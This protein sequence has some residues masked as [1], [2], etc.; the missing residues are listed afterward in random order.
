MAYAQEA[1]AQEDAAAPS[2]KPSWLITPSVSGSLT[3]TDNARPGQGQKQSDFITSVT[4]AVRIDGK[5]GRVSGNLNFSWQQNFYANESR[6]NNDQ[7]SLSATGKAELIEQWLFMDASANIAQNANSVFATQTVG[8]ELV[9][10]NRGTTTSY[11]WSP[12]VQGYLWGSL[13]YELRYRNTQTTAD[14]GVYSTGSGVDS[15]AWNGRLSG[16][17]PFSLLGWSLTAED[18]RT[19]FSARDTKSSR[20][21]GTLEYRFDPQLKFNVSAGQESDNYSNFNT[22]NRTV[23]GYGLDWAPTERTKL[24]LAKEKR[25]F[26]NGHTIDFSHRTALTAWK[27]TDTRSVVIP[28][29]QFTTAAISTAYDLLFLQLA[30]SIPDPVARAQAVSMLLQSA[31]IPANSLI[32]GNIMTSQPFIQRSQQASVSLTGANNTVTFSVQRSSNEQIGTGISTLDDF[33]LSQNI[34][35]SGFSGSWAHKLSP[36]SNL[37]LNALTSRSRGDTSTLDSRL[38]SLSLLYTTRLGSKTTASLGLRQ[39]NYDNASYTNT[40]YTTGDYTEHAITGTVSAS[41]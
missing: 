40:S 26:G 35:Q 4:P 23:S 24:K 10:N 37:T 15:Q 9:N 3:L 1:N 38:R 28:A 41:F 2:G 7:T 5:G 32:Y 25:S 19:T 6:Y 8:N 27:F 18:Q 20:V 31:G 14:T 34:R 17:T 12:Y 11:Q 39:N 29:Q 30:S 33:A 13:N 16:A 22:Q 21:L 36:D